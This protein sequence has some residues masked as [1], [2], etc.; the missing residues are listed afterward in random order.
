MTATEA[1]PGGRRFTGWADTWRFPVLVFL[2][3]LV[4]L[5]PVVQISH[6]HLSPEH[7]QTAPDISD[8]D[9]YGGW[10]Q[11]DTGWYVYVAEHGYDQHQVDEFKAGRMS[12]V[13]YFPAYPL[14]VRQVGRLTSDDYVLAAELT[15]AA[16]GLAVML[17]FWLWCGRHL[18]RS[19][20]RTT[21]LLYALYPYSWFLF[22]TGYGDA[23]FITLTISAMLLVERDRPVLAGLVGAV[24]S[25]A[26]L[27][28]VGTVIGL[29]AI[30]LQRRQAIV[31]RDD[32]DPRHWW[33]GWRLDRSRLRRRDA[34]VLLGF[35]GIASYCMFLWVRT[36][37]FLA[38]NT[39][40]S[41][42]GWNQGTGPKT[43]IKY[44][45]FAEVLRG[46]PG[47][48]VRLLV[49]A[50]LCLVFLAAIP[51]VYKRFG[52]GYAVYTAVIL[53]IPLIGSSS[54]M[55]FGRYLLAAFPVFAVGGELLADR[56]RARRVALVGSSL[57]LLV[58]ASFFGRGFYLS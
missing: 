28:G 48:G 3:A 31:R 29:I 39:V 8:A 5:M 49:Q 6:D 23:L 54:F 11:F 46:S 51:L 24:A 55:G 45:F 30:T 26:R 10:M 41:A 7:P 15:T 2:A 9:R 53:A 34:G 20:R 50:L 21:L 44:S 1:R 4:V 35:G 42:P 43:W 27:I 13:A 12:A 33:S 19:A 47:Y 38:W 37:D 58:L 17:L 14:T 32:D 52:G 18:S 16:C 22:G 25:A 57:G 56:S 40:Q 36:G